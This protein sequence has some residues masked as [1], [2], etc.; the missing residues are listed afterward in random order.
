MCKIFKMLLL[1]LLLVMV[2]LLVNVVDSV[3]GCWKIID[4]KIGKVKLI[5]EIIQVINGIL[6]GKVVEILYLD[7]GFN[8][9]CDGC[10][11]VNKNKLVK[12]MIILWNFKVDGVS[13][14]FGGIILDLVNGKM[15][16]FKMKLQIGGVKF[17]VFG[18]V[19]FIC[20]VQIWVCE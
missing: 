12:G 7:K 4:D 17:D 9:V 15:Y 2:V 14:W 18:C 20:C 5:V 13:V 16:K 6:I 3:V 10:E 1:V 19:V 11:G 8:L